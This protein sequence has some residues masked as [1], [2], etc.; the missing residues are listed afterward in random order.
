MA[1]PGIPGRL[2]WTFR[3]KTKGAAV[4]FVTRPVHDPDGAY[5]LANAS[6]MY[7]CFHIAIFY[8]KFTSFI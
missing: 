2:F 6:A 3:N 1:R 8:L 5:A 4:C 7:I